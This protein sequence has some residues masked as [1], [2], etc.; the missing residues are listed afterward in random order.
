MQK[1]GGKTNLKSAALVALA[2]VIAVPASSI[3]PA[4]A[5][6]SDETAA[7]MKRKKKSGSTA[8]VKKNAVGTGVGVGK[9]TTET[10]IVAGKNIAPML[11]VDG[12]VQLQAALSRY[13][14]IVA[15]GGWPTVPKGT[16]KKGGENKGIAALNKRLFIEGYLRREATEGQFAGIYT[17]ATEDA[18]ARFQRNHGLAVTG[19]VDGPTLAQLNVSA[20]ARLRAIRANIP[21]MAEYS[22]DLSSRYVV[23]NIPAQVIETVNN[24]K[25]FSRHNAVVGRPE[26][27]TPVVM[28][29]VSDINFNPYWNAPPSIIEKDLVP[30]IEKGGSK[31]M[32]DMNIKVFDGVGGPEVDPGDIDWDRAVVDNYHFRQEPGPENAMATAKI[33]F[34]SPF[35]IYLHDTPE[36]HLLQT[37]GRFYSS[38]CV[39][40]DKVAVLLNWILNGQDGI[41]PSQIE[42]LAQ[43][44]ERKDVKLV[45]PPQLRVAYLT[46]WPSGNGTVAFRDDVYDLDGSGF[47]V[48]Q[49]MPVSE[50]QDGQ[51]FVLKPIPRLVAEVD[52]GNFGGFGLFSRKPV[53]KKKTTL[54]DN[55]DE[56]NATSNRIVKINTGKTVKQTNAKTAKKKPHQ[57]LFDWEAYRKGEKKTDP[58]VK[59]KAA[60][61]TKK[62]EDETSK[63]A[64]ANALSAK[65]KK[66]AKKVDGKTTEEVASAA[67]VKKKADPA[68]VKKKPVE[69]A[70]KKKPVGA[71]AAKSCK[72]DASGKLPEGCKPQVD[73]KKVKPKPAAADQASAN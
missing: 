72:P 38:G 69:P 66:K 48:G 14:Q 41:G 29:A 15:Q 13:E 68:V 73:A 30:R 70:A 27:P 12:M 52:N 34:P 7:W 49:P 47:V 61:K 60:A 8:V 24:G 67:P 42:Y 63:K 4:F 58:S 62:K 55:D 44:L 26:R 33:N 19:R 59:K 3:L 25:V 2:L 54:L 65:S 35:G 45:A 37:G 1:L 28:T 23:V 43:S 32:A 9:A 22:K 21:R 6:M 5:E 36:K 71:S 51:R 31:A 17:S 18:V 57:G 16:Y 50:T 53:S 56:D 11:A 46:A 20:Q 64:L 40:V 39:R 10:E